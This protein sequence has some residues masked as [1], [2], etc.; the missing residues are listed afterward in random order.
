MVPDGSQGYVCHCA[1]AKPEMENCWK[2]A[3]HQSNPS[4]T[5]K[6]Q[7]KPMRYVV[8]FLGQILLSFTFSDGG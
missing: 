7:R 6:S 4:S 5:P 3:Y 1:S 8:S 2:V